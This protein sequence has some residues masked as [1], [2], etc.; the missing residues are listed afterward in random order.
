VTP[1]AAG[2]APARCLWEAGAV[3]GEG[4]LWL[5]EEGALYWLDI[6]APAVHRVVP[7]TGARQSWPMPERIGFLCPRRGGGFIGGLKSGLALIDLDGGRIE[8][9]G[10]PETDLP[11]NRLND[12]KADA[13]GRLWFGSMD[14]NEVAPTGRLYRLDADRSWR[15]LDDG[16][17][18][19][20]GPAFSPDGG[21]LYHTDTFARTI[22]A[23]DLSPD[24]ELDNKRPF[25]TIPAEAGYPD[26]MTVDAEGHLWVAHWGGWR[27]SRYRPDGSLE[28]ILPLPVSQVTS[29]AFGGSDLET[30]Y[31]TTAAIGLGEAA[32]RDQPLAGGLFEV[33]VGIKG[34]PPGRYAG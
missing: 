28:R 29:C 18:V 13:A 11:D 31:I 23:F 16:Y 25:V 9:F 3:L 17:V 26:G 20:N 1:P 34:L 12:G 19:T 7:A 10:G 8:P 6:K 14:D 27:L 22:H 21:R 15:E 5:A 24:G 32:L 4:P 33:P 30:L 2:P